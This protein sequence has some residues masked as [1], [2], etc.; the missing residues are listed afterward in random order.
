MRV[1]G[2]EEPDTI[3]NLDLPTRP[4][5]FTHPSSET[6]NTNILMTDG[7]NSPLST[8]REAEFRHP[9][10]VRAD[11]GDEGAQRQ[12]HAILDMYRPPSLM[13]PERR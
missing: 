12:I 11:S 4:P 8:P 2:K 10:L 5:L 6:V 9:G 3:K 1:L 7:V 13:P